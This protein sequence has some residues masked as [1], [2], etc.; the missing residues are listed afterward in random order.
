MAVA[1]A[2]ATYC[3]AGETIVAMLALIDFAARPVEH[4]GA[5]A[6]AQLRHDRYERRRICGG[7]VCGR[8]PIRLFGLGASSADASADEWFVEYSLC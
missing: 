4:Q 2:N 5:A 8:P 6:L 7:A 1:V 3:P